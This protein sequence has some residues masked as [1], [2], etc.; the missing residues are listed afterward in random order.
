LL[1]GNYVG[2]LT[3]AIKIRGEIVENAT[4]HAGYRTV[5]A[6]L[7]VFTFVLV[8]AIFVAFILF[9]THAVSNA[10]EKRAIEIVSANE[11]GVTNMMEMFNRSQLATVEKFARLYADMWPGTFALDESRT[12]DTGGTPLPAL[13]YDGADVNN[14][15]ATIDKFSAMTG[16]N[17]TVF[18][19]KGDDFFRVATSVK[20]ADGS[21]A[22]GTNL[23]KTHPAYALLMKG[24]AY[25]GVAV[26]FGK[27]NVTSY[28]PIKDA[29]GAVI[30]ILYVGIDISADV[31]ALKE[32]IKAIKVG[33]SGYFFVMDAKKGDTQGN[34]IVH[35][36]ME[37]KSAKA[38]RST[39][40]RDIA[41]QMLDGKQGLLRFVIDGDKDKRERIIVYHTDKDWN[42][43][44]GGVAL[45]DEVAEE[46]SH[47]R[48]MAFVVG[49]VALLALAALLYVMVK[50][51]VSQPLGEATQAAER[52][53]Q[54]DLTVRVA[55]H[56]KDEIGRLM[57]AMNGI[58]GSLAKVVS[59]IREGTH[60]V[61]TA[62]AEIAAG[63]QDLSARTER[64]ASAL[65]QTASSMEELTSTV[66]Q[67][68]DNAKQANQLA[69]SASQV[70]SKGGEVVSQVVATMESISDSSKKV[71]DII[72]VIDG[73][74]FQTNI[75]ALNASV[76]AA[77]AGEQGRGFAV[78]ASEVRSLAQRSASAAK[79]IKELIGNSANQVEVGGKLVA[80][81][82]ATMSEV[83]ESVHKVTDIMAEIM[84]ATQEQSSGINEINRAITD[85]D[86]TTQQ[87][88]TIVEAAANAAQ[89]MQDMAARLTQAVSVF[90]IEG[91][92]ATLADG[93]NTLTPSASAKR[94]R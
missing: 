88:V 83:V 59:A 56:G 2:N 71:V 6:K 47:L 85:M 87:N 94:L 54:G 36:S 84:A 57:G 55:A 79:E 61:A 39:D 82:G 35:P 30:G 20:K 92:S 73:I 49:I 43:V 53:A 4:A 48:I 91:T 16:G 81:A 28:V 78:V 40:G 38:L 8:T 80:E 64:Q 15:F 34:F 62:S 23:G 46:I 89:S 37:G 45:V 60:Q 65:E 1:A 67:N 7:T 90:R 26:L 5:G 70:A 77:R 17:A 58:S 75:L 11:A 18:L 10:L 51:L 41:Q 32:R 29:K 33:N 13:Q 74:A 66:G 93:V 69:T 42:W 3:N 44:I 52:L 63:N 19:K 22:V 50:R 21:R 9:L 24:E 31:A 72:G 14:N 25:R 68:A 76:E 27:P 86:Q 12:I